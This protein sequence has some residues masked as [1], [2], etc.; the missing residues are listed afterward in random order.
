MAVTF[1]PVPTFFVSNVAP[2]IETVTTSDPT[3][4]V[5]TLLEIV[6]AVVPS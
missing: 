5:N 3:F 2:P 1:L 4:P 6:A